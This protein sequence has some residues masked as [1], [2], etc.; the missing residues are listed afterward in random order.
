M[1]AEM[2]RLFG[3]ISDT[4]WELS[5]AERGLSTMAE[6]GD[7]RRSAMSRNARKGFVVRRGCQATPKTPPPLL[8]SPNICRESML[9]MSF[10]IGRTPPTLGPKATKFTTVKH[11]FMAFTR[12]EMKLERV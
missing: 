7:A 4:K 9:I 8:R 10:P 1:G 6:F 11:R 5:A 2:G 12:G 3:V